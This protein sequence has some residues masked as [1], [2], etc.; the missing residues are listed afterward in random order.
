M[1][2]IREHLTVNGPYK[3]AYIYIYIHIYIYIYTH[4]YVYSCVYVYIYIYI[5]DHKQGLGRR[6]LEADPDLDG[7]RSSTGPWLENVIVVR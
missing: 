5:R 4:T 7:R 2:H 1:V 3:R 6:I